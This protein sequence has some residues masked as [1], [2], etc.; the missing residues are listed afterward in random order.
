M[1]CFL[2]AINGGRYWFS[3]QCFL[4][5]QQTGGVWLKSQTPPVYHLPITDY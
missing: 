3:N 1:P 2:F 4:S 5:D